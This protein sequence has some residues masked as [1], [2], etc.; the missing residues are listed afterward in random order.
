MK[1][2]EHNEDG[3]EHFVVSPSYTRVH[4]YTVM[5]EALCTSV[6]SFAVIASDHD[7][8]STQNTVLNINFLEFSVPKALIDDA[9]IYRIISGDADVV[10]C[11]E[12][13]QEEVNCE[14][15]VK[16]R[17]VN[18]K[19]RADDK[20]RMKYENDDHKYE[21]DYLLGYRFEVPGCD[22]LVLAFPWLQGWPTIVIVIVIRHEVLKDELNEN[23]NNMLIYI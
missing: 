15:D 10:Y 21:G 2:N 14:H 6:A 20:G 1:K 3:H 8:R 23:S 5:V 11:N 7:I 9:A 13:E 22:R 4:V 12:N 19:E 17:M 18:S 16:N